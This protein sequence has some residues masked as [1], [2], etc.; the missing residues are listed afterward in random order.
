MKIL[1]DQHL[2][3]LLAHGGAN[4]QVEQTLLALQR[5]GVE[6]EFLRWWDGAQRGDLIHFFGVPPNGYLNLARLKHL[7][8]ITNQLFTDTCNR[9]LGKLKWQG[10]LVNAILSL[11]FGE[12]VKQQLTWRSY[13]KCDHN[14][15]GLAAEKQVLQ[16]VY[17]IA[18]EKISVV[19]Y[20]LTDAYMKAGAGS[21]K[22]D[23][24]ICTGTITPRK[25]QVELATLARAGQVPILFV[26]KAYHEADPYW[27]Q[28]KALIDGRW[29][30]HQPHVD[31]ESEM[32]SLLQAA[33]G[34]VLMSWYENWCLSAHEAAACGLPLLVLDQNW[35]RERFGDRIKFFGKL[36]VNDENSWALKNFY[37]AA[38]QLTAPAVKLYSWQEVAAELKKT[39]A[40]VL[41]AA[42]R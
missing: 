41:A 25:C 17:R 5:E 35:S 31:S 8:V 19:P 34:F 42:A 13:Q 7:P 26:G 2:P 30:K 9:P 20:G 11:P 14:I 4:T 38:P 24:L 37:D 40:A 29:V 3:F 27:L 1:I 28:F 23:H 21:R 33:R 39:Y 36:G 32:I 12:G 16:V 6:V 18:S 10:R 22:E 15:V